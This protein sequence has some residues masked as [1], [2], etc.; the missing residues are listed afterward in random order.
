MWHST[1]FQ[2]KTSQGEKEM[3]H[4]L[5]CH[6]NANFIF[7]MQTFMRM[8]ADALVGKPLKD[9]YENSINVGFT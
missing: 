3:E 8:L 5:S 9:H 2:C 6:S 1:F 4:Q 7:R